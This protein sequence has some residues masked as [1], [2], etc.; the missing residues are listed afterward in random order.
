MSPNQSNV[1]SSR[2]CHRFIGKAERVRDHHKLRVR[3]PPVIACS[4]DLP[5]CSRPDQ[6]VRFGRVLGLRDGPTVLPQAMFKYHVRATF[7]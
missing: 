2:Q 1:L 4:D 3:L 5:Y 6:S 7:P